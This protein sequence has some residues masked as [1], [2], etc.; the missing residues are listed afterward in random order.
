[1]LGLVEES[2]YQ[3]HL[4]N[5]L[6]GLC[7]GDAC[8]TAVHEVI[9]QAES[10][11]VPEEICRDSGLCN[12]ECVLFS[13]WPIQSLPPSPPDWPIERRRSLKSE[14]KNHH[15]DKDHQKSH[16]EIDYTEFGHVMTSVFSHIQAEREIDR[17]PSMGVISMALGRIRTAAEGISAAER[18]HYDSTPA[19]EECAKNVSCH[20]INFVDGHLPLKDADGDRF[21]PADAPRLRGSHWR[22]ADCNDEVGYDRLYRDYVLLL[23]NISCTLSSTISGCL[24]Y[25]C[26][27]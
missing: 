21:A 22:G 18:D 12:D 7:D 2:V 9:M 6:T 20:L 27:S 23:L 3:V 11:R 10:G 1:M 25:C 19:F 8:R 15:H 24:L 4:E 26:Y 5:Y 17:I 13:E 16:G 14:S